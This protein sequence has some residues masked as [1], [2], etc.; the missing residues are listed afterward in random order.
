[1]NADK[2]E[3]EGLSDKVK[4]QRKEEDLLCKTYNLSFVY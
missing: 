4:K 3:L 1:M 2:N